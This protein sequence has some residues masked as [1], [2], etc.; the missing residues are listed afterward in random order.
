MLAH[1]RKEGSC[2]WQ[3][4][5]GA[6]GC[7]SKCVPEPEGETLKTKAALAGRSGV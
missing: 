4:G 6:L 7:A 1:L 2:F 5:M 3:S